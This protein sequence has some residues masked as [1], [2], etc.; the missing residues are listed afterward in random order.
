MPETET[1]FVPVPKA[2]QLDRDPLG[3]SDAN[4]LAGGDDLAM[5]EAA[6]AADPGEVITEDLG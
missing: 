5:I 6:R 4:A 2:E 1:E 3:P